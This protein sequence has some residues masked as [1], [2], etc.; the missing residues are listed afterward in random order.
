MVFRKAGLLHVGILCLFSASAFA[1]TASQI[2]NYGI[3]WTFDH[4]YTV[5]RFANGD[6]WIVGPVTIIAIA[7]AFDG[8]HHGWQVNP[9]VEASQGF[10]YRVNSFT[11]AKVP[12]LPYTAQPGQ[13]LV[14]AVSNTPLDNTSC[15]P[16][17]READVLTVLATVPPD[18]GATVFRPPY[19]GSNKAWYS[20]SELRTDILP[21]VAPTAALPTLARVESTFARVHLDH[22]PDWVGDYIHPLLNMNNNE[23]GSSIAIDNAEAALRLML[24]DPLASKR[25]ALIDYVQYGI[26]TYYMASYGRTWEADGGHGWGRMLPVTFAAVMLDN[27]T[28][29]NFVG[30]AAD[31]V[32]AESFAIYYSAQANNGLGQVL[33]GEASPYC[34]TRLYWN[35]LVDHNVSGS[36]TCPDPHGYIDGGESVG[37]TYDFCCSIQPMKQVAIALHIFPQLMQVWNDDRIIKYSDRRATVGA[38]AQPDPCAPADG[39]WRGIGPKN[40]TRCTAAM[41]SPN[42]GDTCVLSMVNYGKTFG[43]DS[44]HP[45]DCIRDTDPSDGIGRYPLKHGDSPDGGYYTSAFANQLWAKYRDSVFTSVPKV[46]SHG[47]PAGFT[48]KVMG[49]PLLPNTGKI[50]ISCSLVQTQGLELGIYTVRGT[51]VRQLA[52]KEFSG[53]DHVLYWDGKDENRRVAGNGLYYLVAQ[54]GTG[55]QMTKITVIR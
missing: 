30:A 5:G 20:T 8:T 27:Q 22:K 39:V 42:N 40:G 52:K 46:T 33:Y 9:Q 13:S 25:Q 10:D 24:N 6:H 12:A 47:L 31:H 37:N 2:T 43:P 36:K 17:L 50:W 16:C 28:M 55:R 38:W 54:A 48:I 4:A 11:A 21:S 51:L 23:Y 18:S 53:G 1:G 32:F 49:N 44:L 34:N 14:K 45:A 7:P 41:L 3:T 15:R 29:K 19:V 26:D 35:K